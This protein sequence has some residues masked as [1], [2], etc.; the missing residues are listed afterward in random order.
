MAHPPDIHVETACLQQVFKPAFETVLT[1]RAWTEVRT[2]L[3]MAGLCRHNQPGGSPAETPYHVR[4][5][6]IH[7]FKPG[8]E[9]RPVIG[10]SY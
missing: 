4:G 10:T 1:G 8:Y 6:G 2:G 7:G 5:D 3:S 9:V